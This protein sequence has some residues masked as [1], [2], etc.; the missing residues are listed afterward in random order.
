MLAFMFSASL[1]ICSKAL[2]NLMLLHVLEE[3]YSSD[4]QLEPGAEGLLDLTKGDEGQHLALLEKE[5]R[6]EHANCRSCFR[7][8]VFGF[9]L[10]SAVSTAIVDLVAISFLMSRDEIDPASPIGVWKGGDATFEMFESEG[11]LSARIVGLSVPKTAEGKEKTD[12]YNPDPKKR[13]CPII[14]L[15]F[16]SGFTRTSDTR[17]ENGTVYDPKSGKT[18]SCFMELEGPGKIKVR[19]FLVVPLMGRNYFWTRAD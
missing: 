12:I 19:G 9:L 15:V 14:G 16:I 18:Y 10:L 2:A 17:W 5:L 4:T 11:K 7:I 1:T 13:S 8:G 3:P 6:S